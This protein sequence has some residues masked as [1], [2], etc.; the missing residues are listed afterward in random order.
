LFPAAG[1]KFFECSPAQFCS[2]FA[3]MGES[4]KKRAITSGRWGQWSAQV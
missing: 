3:D 1:A 2:A 4:S